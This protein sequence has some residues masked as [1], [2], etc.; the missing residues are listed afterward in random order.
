MPANRFLDSKFEYPEIEYFSRCGGCILQL[1][2]IDSTIQTNRYSDSNVYINYLL[3]NL[4]KSAIEWQI[5]HLIDASN[6]KFIPKNKLIDCYWQRFGIAKADR[7]ER[8]EFNFEEFDFNSIVVSQTRKKGS[9]N[10][11]ADEPRVYRLL[12]QAGVN[13]PTGQKNHVW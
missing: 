10:W 7:N 9:P 13:L 1:A 8:C 2:S 5:E 6:F 3:P 4:R 12:V 11:I